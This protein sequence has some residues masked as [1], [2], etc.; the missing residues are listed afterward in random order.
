MGGCEVMKR[1]NTAI[2][3]DVRIVIKYSLVCVDYVDIPGV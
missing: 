2:D 3:A 1:F